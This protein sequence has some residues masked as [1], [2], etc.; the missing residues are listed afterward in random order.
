MSWRDSFN[1]PYSRLARVTYGLSRS[2]RSSHS[3]LHIALRVLSDLG[4]TSYVTSDCNPQDCRRR[5]DKPA[6]AQAH[7]E[8]R[9]F[10]LRETRAG[11]KPCAT[12]GR[13]Q[14]VPKFCTHVKPLARQEMPM[15]RQLQ[16][17][18]CDSP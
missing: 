13:H 12:E 14:L 18:S 3:P 7:E 4:V 1:L 11:L 8:K 6:Q 16:L 17:K 15:P 5:I 10:R 2:A 9:V